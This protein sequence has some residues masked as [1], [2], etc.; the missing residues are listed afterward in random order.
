MSWI[1]WF[2]DLGR[3][4]DRS[5]T[6]FSRAHRAFGRRDREGDSDSAMNPSMGAR[7][8]HSGQLLKSGGSFWVF[9]MSNEFAGQ[10]RQSEHQ[11]QIPLRS[12]RNSIAMAGPLT[13]KISDSIF[14]LWLLPHYYLDVVSVK[15]AWDW[16]DRHTQSPA[17][18]AR[19]SST[20][21]NTL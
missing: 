1:V 6:E 15:P 5:M 18:A 12:D 14:A 2:A 20:R 10:Y 3:R 16:A 4:S 8:V 9:R 21:R 7:T 13:N 11:C 17:G 19:S